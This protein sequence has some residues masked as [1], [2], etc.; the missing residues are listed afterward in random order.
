MKISFVE[1][2]GFRGIRNHLRINIPDGFVVITGRNGSGKST[3]CDAIEFALTGELSKY[4]P[5]SERGESMDD[6]IWWRGAAPADRK[7]VRVG[8]CD[9]D[10]RE[11]VLSRT[12]DGLEVA[13]L[14]DAR[15]VEAALCDLSVMSSD[16]LVQLCRTAI[17]RDETLAAMSVDRSEFD[18]FTFV[19]TALGT[20]A[21]D[22]V[23]RRGKDVLTALA[24]DVQTAQTAYEKAR[25]DV[26]ALLAELA[27]ARAESSEV[28]DAVAAE[29]EVRRR[30]GANAPVEPSRLLAA[31]RQR[32]A[33]LRA[34]GDAV[35]RLATEAQVLE[36]EAA[37]LQGPDAVAERAAL[38]SR[39]EV[40]IAERA[41]LD[42]EL[43]ASR[44]LAASRQKSA[45]V[46]ARLAALHEAGRAVGLRNGACPLCAATQ[47]LDQFQAALDALA[48]ELEAEDREAASVDQRTAELARQV[49]QLTKDSKALDDQLRRFDAA[50]NE[51][52]RRRALLSEQ[53]RR[54]GAPVDERLDRE[55]ALAFARDV[56]LDAEALGSALAVLEASASMERVA[57]IERRL[58][59]ARDSSASLEAELRRLEAAE[60]RAKRLIKGVRRAVG[61][62]VEERL[63]SLDPLLK[64]LYARLR[65][66]SDWTDLTYTVRGDVKK[67][68][69]LT[70]GS[71]VNPRY[72]F[73]SGQRRAIGLAFL[74][75]VHLS[76]PWC[77]LRTLILDDPVQHIDDFRALHLV[78][79]L[80]AVRRYG[81]QI[82]CA[83]EDE[84]LAELI[85]RRVRS[86]RD[87][88]GLMVRMAYRTGEGAVVE[89]DRTVAP[90]VRH[91]VVP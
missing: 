17:I 57:E 51:L 81:Q 76:R 40:V 86:A 59:Q 78:E 48:R 4:E 18:R 83:V 55:E 84:E 7:R 65:P 39:R 26:T 22:D 44:A 29:G 33:T 14:A 10:G 38:E 46:R 74:L 56:Q 73:S 50:E 32:V 52:G 13:G 53:L 5:G 23:T 67:L 90:A 11:F 9:D 58:A 71:E 3:V 85:C 31:A 6:Y 60:S 15:E 35:V 82:I 8:I 49:D 25:A 63:A 34:A 42:V 75:A 43:V 62:V 69:S 27:R 88:E 80:S 12:P 1:V 19:R 47:S 87:G 28:T 41:H 2:E 30:L 66:H 21:L 72:T 24:T 45:P 79:V 36:Q 68:L 61:E 16:P 64:D 70:V 20:D 77:R 91:L 89:N 37:I 54:H